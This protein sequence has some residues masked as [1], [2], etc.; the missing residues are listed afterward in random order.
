MWHS[1]KGEQYELWSDHHGGY[2]RV[3]WEGR[4][5]RDL[6]RVSCSIILKALAD[7]SIR[8]AVDP[9]QVDLFVASDRSGPW[10]G[11]YLGAPLLIPFGEGD[12]G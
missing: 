8:D 6:T 5:P 3:P 1:R 4:S 9:L 7:K 2:V 12:H 11:S 10:V